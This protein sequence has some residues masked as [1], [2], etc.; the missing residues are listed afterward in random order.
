[1]QWLDVKNKSMINLKSPLLI[2]ILCLVF[3]CKVSTTSED[4]A[5][6]DSVYFLK[7]NSSNDFG[8]MKESISE[9]SIS[10][11]SHKIIIIDHPQP[12]AQI[13]SPLTLKG[14]ARGKWYF[15]GDFYAELLDADSTVIA[16]AIVK[17]QDN[18]MTTSFVPFIEQMQFDV[19]NDTRGFVAFHKSNP[20]GLPER[21]STIYVPVIIKQHH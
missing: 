4:S 16:S 18:W 14:K 2:A 3:S 9:E 12:G 11:S 13:E 6:S 10:T 20:S 17:A 7:E 1:M 21:D 8:K 19:D 5:N 15:E